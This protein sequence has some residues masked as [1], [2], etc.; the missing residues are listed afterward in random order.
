MFLE[1]ITAILIMGA[2]PDTGS[3]PPLSI[4]CDTPQLMVDDTLIAHKSG[5]FRK[6]HPCT[7]LPEPVLSAETPCEHDGDDRRVYI[8][9]TVL[10]DPETGRFRM[11]YNRLRLVLYAESED[12]LHWNRPNLGISDWE[13]NSANNI[14]YTNLHSPSLT[15]NPG[16]TNP[17][18]RYA[19][20]GSESGYRILIS[21]DGL[22]WKPGADAPVLQG[23]DTCT[24]T[25]D[26]PT[27]EYLAFHKHSIEY[28]GHS[29]RLAYLSTSRDLQTWSEP[30]LVMAPD[31]IDDAQVVREGGEYAQFYN[32]SVFPYGGQY[33]GMVT[34]FHFSG[35]SETKEKG[36]SR[37]DGRIDVQ[38]VHSRD[39]RHWAR[40]EDRSPIIPNGPHSYDT[41]C[42]LGVANGP[43]AVGDELWLY[44]TAINT[45]HGGALPGKQAAIALAK[46]PRDRFVSLETD[47]DEGVI[48]TVPLSCPGTRLFVNADIRGNISIALLDASGQPL[49]GYGHEDCLPLKGDHLR[50]AVHW[51]AHHR[52]PPDTAIRMQF[53]M[54]DAD[55][56][57]FSTQLQ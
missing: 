52:L 11:W 36:Q 48:G 26:P 29:R 43:V 47:Q 16:V 7:K 38:L 39:G 24:L 10:R 8:Y 22:H 15:Y 57:S 32:M 49:A 42:I 55:L 44:Y 9:G 34:L 31:E 18:Q 2:D 21:N 13:G 4:A 12:G 23:G 3:P 5:V 51:K 45:T 46:W 53:K 40:C 30:A 17:E 6:V 56:F 20:L 28:R 14:V 33:L 35:A 25:F 1:I 54:Q 50:H 41:G 27:G 19:I 37:H